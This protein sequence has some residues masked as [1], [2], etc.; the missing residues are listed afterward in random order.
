MGFQFDGVPGGRAF[1]IKPAASDVATN[2]TVYTNRRSYYFHVV[3]ALR[4]AMGETS[5]KAMRGGE[6]DDVIFAGTATRSGRNLAEVTLSLED[7][8][9]LAPPPNQDQPEL[10]IMRRINRGE[11][12]NFRVNGKEIRAR[13]VQTMCA[14]I[15]SGAR[16]S[17]MVSQ[18]RV[19]TLIQAC[20][21]YTSR[22][23]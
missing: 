13:D 19:S 21:L 1:A 3:E 4:W 22:C 5:A 10:E 6:M 15:G 11:G 8:E 20:L 16:A 9:G 17:A 12:S 18:G 2:I 14:D 7:A 23:V